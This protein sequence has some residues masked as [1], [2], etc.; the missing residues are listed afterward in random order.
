MTEIDALPHPFDAAVALTP[1]F[2]G[3]FRGRTR[4]EYAHLLGAFGGITAATLVQVVQQH[5]DRLG[6]PLSLTVN[7]AVPVA[8]GDFD[9]TARVTRTNRKTQHWL[10]E[11][12][13]DGVVKTTATAVYGLHRATWGDTELLM[14]QVPAPDDVPVQSLAHIT[15]LAANYEMR[16]VQ[17][18]MPDIF[19]GAD[20][21][22]DST[23]TLWVRD[24]P[25]RP[26]D[27][28]ALTALSDVFYPRVLLRRGRV[29]AAS[30]V[31]LTIY[32]HADTEEI[33]AQG[34]DHILA[35]ART[36][37]FS[38]GYYDQSGHLW[39]QDGTLLASSHQL[40]YFKE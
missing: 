24:N 15:A 40:V 1:T 12:V 33:A 11:L 14:P 20:E 35:T 3:R 39:G 30:T 28:S 21:H 4:P 6:D 31:T 10:F 22:P 18:P 32:F 37:R 36:N 27:A 19:A 38:R 5:P 9:I 2:D 34:K 8:D 26:L 16:F 7:Y 17:G 29:A 13:Q 23:T 25:P